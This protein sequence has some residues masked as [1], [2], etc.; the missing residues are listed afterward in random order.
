M[1]FLQIFQRL[2]RECDVAGTAPT[3]VVGQTGEGLRLKEWASQAFVDLQNKRPNWEWMRTTKSFDTVASQ[4]SYDITT[5]LSLTD[6]ASWKKD[7]FRI[8]LKSAGVGNEILL[9]YYEYNFFRNYWELGIQTTNESRPIAISAKPDKDLVFGPVPDAVY[10]VTGEY[11]KT[12]TELSLDADTPE[13]PDRFHMLIV[14]LAMMDYGGFE[15]AA[16]VYERGRVKSREMMNKLEIDQLPE[17]TLGRSF[18]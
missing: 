9:P 18:I 1:T 15:A 10:T 8:Y 16:E 12:A 2:W 3:T 4:Q 14:Y 7:S 13:L 5:D 6:F 11:Y 17:I